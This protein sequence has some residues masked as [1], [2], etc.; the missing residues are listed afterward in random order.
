MTLTLILTRHA[1]SDWSVPGLG[2]H[3]RPLN[4]RGRASARAIGNWLGDRGHSPEQ[5]LCSDAARTRETYGLIR[6][7]LTGSPDPELMRALYLAPPQT[8]LDVLRAQGS[9]RTVMMVGHN[10]G[11]A[12]MATML[13]ASAPA[14]PDFQRYP[15]AFTTVLTFLGDVWGAVDWGM[16]TVVD[17]VAPRRLS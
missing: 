15:T 16:G 8:M 9:G 1:K 2:D 11:C 17:C 4:K 10:P 6:N 12:T 7:G 5:V 3:E 13:A 14:D